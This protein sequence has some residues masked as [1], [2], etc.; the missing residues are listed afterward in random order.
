MKKYI[1]PSTVVENGVL[2]VSIMAGSVFN[3]PGD[4]ED[5][6]NAGVFDKDE[7]QFLPSEKGLWED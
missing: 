4:E 7:N 3:E 5:A 2:Q 6:A 1:Q